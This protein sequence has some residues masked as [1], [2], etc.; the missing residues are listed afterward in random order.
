ME[1]RVNAVE[2]GL[3]K[4]DKPL[5]WSFRGGTL[6]AADDWDLALTVPAVR[7]AVLKPDI[8]FS[9]G[10]LGV[11]LEEVWLGRTQTLLL[12]GGDVR[13]LDLLEGLRLEDHFGSVYR[14]IPDAWD[15]RPT[16]F[17]FEPIPASADRLVVKC[18]GAGIRLRGKWRIPLEAGASGSPVDDDRPPAPLEEPVEPA[19]DIPPEDM[20]DLQE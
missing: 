1:I 15:P 9:L 18:K 8:D 16:Q 3:L 10:G 11:R 5:V 2:H 14:P 6:Y 4:R 7:P 13:E 12:F 19:P 17:A 20:Q